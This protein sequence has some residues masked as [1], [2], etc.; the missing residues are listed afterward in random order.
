[1]LPSFLLHLQATTLL[2]WIGYFLLKTHVPL[3]V[4]VTPS[5]L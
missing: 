5:A 3:D 2:D 4:I 1:M